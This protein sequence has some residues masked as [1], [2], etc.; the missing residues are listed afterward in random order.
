LKLGKL[1]EGSRV[2]TIKVFIL[3][4]EREG[5]NIISGERG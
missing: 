2:S 3:V 4:G 1:I 5:K